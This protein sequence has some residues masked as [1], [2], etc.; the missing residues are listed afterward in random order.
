MQVD[1]KAS[2]TLVRAQ[3]SPIVFY[4]PSGGLTTF[5]GF[6]RRKLNDGKRAS[7]PTIN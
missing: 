4:G 3:L 7:R 1:L 2:I 5:A 6:R